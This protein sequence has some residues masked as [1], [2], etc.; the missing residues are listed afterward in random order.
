MTRPRYPEKCRIV[1]IREL[2]HQENLTYKLLNS[3]VSSN[4]GIVTRAHYTNLFLVC[5]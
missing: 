2:N 4:H 3:K 1:Y 5:V